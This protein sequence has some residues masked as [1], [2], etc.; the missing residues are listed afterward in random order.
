M[1]IIPTTEVPASDE[2]IDAI[3][4]IEMSRREMEKRSGFATSCSTALQKL[5]ELLDHES[6]ALLRGPDAG[7][8]GNVDA[9]TLDIGRVKALA[10]PRAQESIPRYVRTEEPRVSWR[11]AP[12]SPA[13]IKGRRTMGRAGGR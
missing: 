8:P 13:R 11:N 12:R 4:E 1:G 6:K 7:H 10:A 2:V 9:L 5:S 3:A